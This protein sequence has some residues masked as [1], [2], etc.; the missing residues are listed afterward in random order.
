MVLWSSLESTP[1][2]WPELWARKCGLWDMWSKIWTVGLM[3]SMSDRLLCS[4]PN[5][6]MFKTGYNM[7][8]KGIFKN[9][10]T[11][12]IYGIIGAIVSVILAG[13]KG[14]NVWRG[15]VADAVVQLLRR[16][17]LLGDGVVDLLRSDHQLGIDVSVLSKQLADLGEMV[18]S[19]WWATMSL[20][21]FLCHTQP[22]LFILLSPC[23]SRQLGEGSCES[24]V[25]EESND[26]GETVVQTTS[27]EGKERIVR[28]NH[29]HHFNY[30]RV[31]WWMVRIV[32]VGDGR[33][34]KAI[35]GYESN[36]RRSIRVPSGNVNRVFNDYLKVN[37]WVS[38]SL[39]PSNHQVL[40]LPSPHHSML[41]L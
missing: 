37:T 15:S 39:I 32:S 11:I 30:Q 1:L 5:V 24:S 2:C 34:R 22:E 23:P 19:L 20:G 14:R 36:R 18:C 25:G 3:E 7:R 40:T 10:R 26:V 21:H 29:C 16:H 33:R 17:Q 9:S 28:D 27:M 4:M 13:G 8:T 31:A 12:L 6:I 38:I 35:Q 41:L